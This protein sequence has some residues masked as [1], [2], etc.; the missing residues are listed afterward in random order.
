MLF[1]SKRERKTWL[2]LLIRRE[3]SV[4][5]VVELLECTEAEVYDWLQQEGIRLNDV[6]VKP[7]SERDNEELTQEIYTLRSKLAATETRLVNMTDQAKRYK[8]LYEQQK[9]SVRQGGRP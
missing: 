6:T 8:R 3:K 2:G 9:K 1:S 4:K 7:L 5:D